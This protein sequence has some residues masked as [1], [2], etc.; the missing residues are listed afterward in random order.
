MTLELGHQSEIEVA[1]KLAN[2]VDAERLTRLDKMLIAEQ[3]EQ[4]FVDL[5][6]REGSSYLVRENR[7]LMIGRAKCLQ[8]YGLATEAEPGRWVISGRAEATLR[9]LG[10]RGDIIKTMHRALADHG[11]AEER[12]TSQYLPHCSQLTE[13]VIGRVIGK[14]LAGDEMGERVYLVV[15]GVDSRVHHLE[16]ADTARVEDVR[17]GMIIEAAPLAA[18]PRAADLNIADVTDEAGIYRPSAHMERAAAQIERIG[19]DPEAFVRSHVR[20]LEALRRAG[21]GMWNGSTP[22]HGA[23]PPASVSVGCATT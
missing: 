5:R 21:P 1:R 18:R 16:F 4:G 14:G 20:R 8:R 22:I 13:P 15:D 17:R 10:E 2:E 19:G 9:E 11:L 6:P 7:H 23:F 12:G 3:R